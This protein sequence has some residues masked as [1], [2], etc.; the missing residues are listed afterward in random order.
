MVDLLFYISIVHVFCTKSTSG[1]GCADLR[2]DKYYLSD[3]P[4]L[5]P[6]TTAQVCLNST[7][8]IHTCLFWATLDYHI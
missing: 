2:E 1:N 3:H 4:G 5:V 7:F 8:I 6:V